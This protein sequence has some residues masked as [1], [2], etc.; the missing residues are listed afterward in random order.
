MGAVDI[1]LDDCSLDDDLRSEG[2]QREDMVKSFGAQ[3]DH[4]EV[5]DLPPQ[6]QDVLV[7]RGEEIEAAEKDCGI[8]ES[9]KRDRVAICYGIYLLSPEEL[10]LMML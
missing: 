7:R 9:V 2:K 5:S 8:W 10:L 4:M 1:Q 3:V 6:Q